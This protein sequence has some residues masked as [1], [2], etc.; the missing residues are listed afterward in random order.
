MDS[1]QPGDVFASA[2]VSSGNIDTVTARIAG[3]SILDTITIAGAGAGF[4]GIY[5]F[6]AT[7]TINFPGE[8]EVQITATDANA[9]VTEINRSVLISD[10]L[11]E[12]VAVV[13]SPTPSFTNEVFTPAIMSF[14]EES[15]EP[16]TVAGVGVVGYDVTYRLTL[17]SGGQGYYPRNSSD[18]TLLATDAANIT[19]GV[20]DINVANGR[21]DELPETFTVFYSNDENGDGIRDD[22]VPEWAQSGNALIDDLADPGYNGKVEVSAQFFNAN[23]PLEAFEIFVNGELVHFGNLDPNDGPVVVPVVK[24]PAVSSP[25]PGNYVV[26]AQVVDQQ[27][28][29]G[30]SEPVTFSILP[31]DP[32]GITFSR[33]GNDPISQGDSVTFDIVPADPGDFDNIETVTIFDSDSDSELGTAP[34]VRINGVDRFRFT[35]TFN[36]QGSFGR[37]A[38]AVAFNG[39]TVISPPIRVDVQPV[40]DLR[41]TI[42]SPLALRKCLG[43]LTTN[44]SR[45]IR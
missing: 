3:E 19:L 14:V 39:Q 41:I 26:V 6:E 21:I 22:P 33:V 43:L 23:A 11:S 4:N 15:R 27:G 12:P 38:R 31:F 29:V 17:V 28:E 25:P 18:A 13:T 45:R 42:D 40:N 34:K 9:N 44:W 5:N 16:V 32:I 1:I 10:S 8:Y 37:F 35:E 2:R 24:Y 7:K 36:E 30:T 20:P